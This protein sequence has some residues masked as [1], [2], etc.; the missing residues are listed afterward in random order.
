MYVCMYV[1][2]SI[3]LSV[4]LS[5]C[6]SVCLHQPVLLVMAET[7]QVRS[8][9]NRYFLLLKGPPRIFG[10]NFD[11]IFDQ[12]FGEVFDQGFLGSEIQCTGLLGRGNTVLQVYR[13]EK[14]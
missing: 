5:L 1:C 2:M 6:S 8:K 13:D 10:Q 14:F 4:W 12:I 3:C 11:Q 7:S 9:A